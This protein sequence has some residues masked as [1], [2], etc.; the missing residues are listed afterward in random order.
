MLAEIS[1]LKSA[2]VNKHDKIVLTKTDFK[3]ILVFS[4]HRGV[5]VE[6]YCRVVETFKDFLFSVRR[7]LTHSILVHHH[8]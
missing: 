7:A 8:L 1:T 2:L 3:E 4:T 6:R 5:F